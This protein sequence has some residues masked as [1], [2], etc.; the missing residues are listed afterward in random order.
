MSLKQ[1]ADDGWLRPHQ[2][3]REEISGLLSIVDR[4][5][6][7]AAYLD[8]CRIKRNTVEYDVAGAATDA[9]GKELLEFAKTLRKPAAERRRT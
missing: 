1:W 8:A 7:D 2:S 6:A 9:D 4:D 3:S 5:I